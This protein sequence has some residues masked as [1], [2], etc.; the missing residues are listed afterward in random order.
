[1]RSGERVRVTA[2]LIEARGDRHLWADK[3]DRDLRDVLALQSEIAQAIAAEVKVKLTPQEAARLGAARPVNPEAYEAYLRGRQE[4]YKRTEAGVRTGLTFFE[5]AIEK[6]PLYAP[7]HAGLAD[8]Y[9]ILWAY[10]YARPQEVIPKARAA[11]LK[12]LELDETLVEGHTSLARIL[13]DFDWDWG[14]ADKEYR[15]AIELNPNYALAHT[16]YSGLL[17]RVGRGEEGLASA[18]KAQE[19]DPLSPLMNA[20][21]AQALYWER[22][23][24]QAEAQCRKASEL[25]PGFF[26]P[27]AILG[28][29]HLQREMFSE[30]IVELEKAVTLLGGSLWVSGML[31]DAYARAGKN[32]QAQQVLHRFMKS[33]AKQKYI[34]A[35]SVARIY[36]GLGEKD[37]AW[38]WVQRAYEEHDPGL[39]DIGS[40]PGNDLLRSDPRVRELIQRMGLP[41]M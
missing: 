34:L 8:A 16:W 39:S 4:W 1:M 12:S 33:Q 27:H 36:A 7:A 2:Q 10:G 11:A 3:Y 29:V 15:R 24:D 28:E 25:D 35:I 20:G 17:R 6:D 30:A 40:W 5:Q 38:T 32:L 31:G 19:L 14:A 22:L 9:L 23:Y 37:E 41:I 26:Y 18:R 13:S 21:L